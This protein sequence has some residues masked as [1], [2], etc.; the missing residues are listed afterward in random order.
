[1]RQD[2]L[3]R[4]ML[5]SVTSLLLLQLFSAQSGYAQNNWLKTGQDLLGTV[6]TKAAGQTASL[7]E[8]D[9]SKGL[10]EALRI[11]AETVV[12]QLG[13][14]DGFNADQAIHIP[15]PDTMRQVKSALS[16]VGRSSLLDDL[17]LRLNRAAEAATPQAKELFWS[18]IEEMTLQDINGIYNGPK[19]SATRYFQGK[20]SEP[21]ARAMQPIID[22]ALEQA[23]AVQA[24][25]AVMSQY[26]QLPFMPNVKA[27]LSSHVVNRGMAGIFHYLAK[28]EA[29]IRQNPVK[30]TTELLQK[31]FGAK[32]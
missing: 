28:E 9:I 14:Q 6:T 5:C 25:D 18:A 26:A 12:S 32:R 11:G 17:E 15:L 20:M 4:N 24:Y 10:K 2:Q 21:L 30:Q 31:V 1:M 29:A 19:D 8:G 13:Q 23:G 3:F 16:T 27:N 7:S 22:R